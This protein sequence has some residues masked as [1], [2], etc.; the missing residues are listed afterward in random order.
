M[1]DITKVSSLVDELKE[2][3]SDAPSNIELSVVE[4]KLKGSIKYAKDYVK[5]FK[6]EN[7]NK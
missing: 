5:S 6:M 4:E 7:E 2:K 1:L 3:G